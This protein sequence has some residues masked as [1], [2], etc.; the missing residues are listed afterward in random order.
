MH[1]QNLPGV[2]RLLGRKP[3]LLSVGVAN[4]GRRL[5]HPYVKRHVE[6]PCGAPEQI[7]VVVTDMC[8]FRCPM[9]QF[10]HSAAEGYRLNQIGHMAPDVFHKLVE[11]SPSWP[12][13]SFTGGEPL[14]H[15]HIV[16]FV[17]HAHT[18]GNPTQ[19]TTNGWFLEKFAHSLCEAGLDVLVVSV[20]GPREIHDRVRRAGAFERLAAGLQVLLRLPNRPVVVMS[21]AVSDINSDSLT[22]MYTTALD[23]GVDG[24]NFSHLWMQTHEVVEAFNARPEPLFTAD[25][26][27]WDV[28]P[29]AVDCAQLHEQLSALRREGWKHRLMVSEL[30]ALSRSEIERWYRHPA[31][32]VKWKTA[33]CA[34]TRMRVWPDGKVKACREWVVGNVMDQTPMEIWNGPAF[35]RFRRVLATH[36]TIPVCARCCYMAYR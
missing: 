21:M 4:I 2:I 3:R 10:A 7:T 28:D 23:A 6:S 36:G 20:D 9:C 26:I 12:L 22:S 32:P 33:R 13:I 15:P 8:N 29:D 19:L 27:S 35:R 16:D 17:S 1:L 5:V 34:W 24:L 31:E 25:E 18:K 14:L 11:E 30:P